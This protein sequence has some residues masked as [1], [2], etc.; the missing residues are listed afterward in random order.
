MPTKGINKL[1]FDF[2]YLWNTGL[3]TGFSPLPHKLRPPKNLLKVL[4]YK[5]PKKYQPKNST[6]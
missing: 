4:L 3:V 6:K 2:F 1:E 5:K